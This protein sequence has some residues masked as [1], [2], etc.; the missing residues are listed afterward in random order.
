M[1]ASRIETYRKQFQFLA[2]KTGADRFL[3]WW[4]KELSAFVPAWIHAPDDETD[5]LILLEIDSTAAVLKQAKEG[6]WL[7]TGRLERNGIDSAAQKNAFL[8]LLNKLGKR[9]D[10]V[11]LSLATPHLLRKSLKFPLAVE[12]NLAQALEFEMDRHTPFKSDQVYFDYRIIGRDAKVGQLEVQ[13][14]L[15]PRPVVDE[16]LA[17]V[18]SWG[19][20][21]QGI[22]LADELSATPPRANLM[23]LRYG[24]ARR[25]N[26]R[27]ATST[28][29]WPRSPVSC[30]LR[31]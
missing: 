30:C 27:C 13:I 3:A 21:V 4:L 1:S 31:P 22:W 6:K 8:A 18:K 11:G 25:E 14:V 17:L 10:E 15:A 7:E 19:A 12:E 5:R 2:S 16:M 28:L 9:T 24:C 29:C 20:S 23:P 26:R